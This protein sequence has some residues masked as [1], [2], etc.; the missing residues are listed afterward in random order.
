[1]CVFYN[2]II[3]Y[4]PKFPFTF[5]L[6]FRP[7]PNLNQTDVNLNLGSGSQFREMPEPNRQ[8]SSGFRKNTPEP[9]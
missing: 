8:S 1:M 4:Y 9:N 7:S 6:A 3:R 5:G 2:Y